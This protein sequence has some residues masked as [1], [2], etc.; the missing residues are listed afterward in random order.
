MKISNEI[1]KQI[2]EIATKPDN[3]LTN[4]EIGETF[5]IDEATV[6]YHVSKW[7]G[8]LH[9][10]ARS[11]DKVANALADHACDCIQESQDILNDVK[12]SIRQAKEAG[13]SPEKLAPLYGNWI[14]SLELASELLGDIN[15]TPQVTANV[16]IQVNQQYNDF[17]KVILS[18]VNED[19][20]K[21][22]IAM[23]RPAA[24]Y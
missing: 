19:D 23:L 22:I 21:R 7:E 17:V 5:G 2:Y 6:R 18:G 11:D 20:K 12:S 16:G 10:I 1:S 4:R 3:K 8:K 15:R 9:A 13:V 24:I 14:K